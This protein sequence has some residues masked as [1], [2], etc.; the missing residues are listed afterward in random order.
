MYVCMY[1]CMYVHM[2]IVLGLGLQMN[3]CL[4]MYAYKVYI[5]DLL[6]ILLNMQLCKI[7]AT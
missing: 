4:N 2:D 1:V 3:V 7:S 5:R 6:Y